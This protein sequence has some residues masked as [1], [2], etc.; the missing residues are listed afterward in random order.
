MKTFPDHR[1]GFIAG[2]LL[3]ASSATQAHLAAPVTLEFEGLSGA[4]VFGAANL[5]L[6]G[7]ACQGSGLCYFED[8]LIIGVVDD[9]TPFTGEHLHRAGSAGD[10]DLSYHSDSSGIYGRTTDGHE[11]ALKSMVFNAPIST[12]VDPLNPDQGPNDFWEILGFNVA[13]NPDLDL[14]DGTTYATRVAY[15]TVAN[16]FTGTLTLNEDFHDINAF[17]IHYRG[18]P[19]V[20]SVAKDFAVRIDDL[21]VGPAEVHAVPVPA[22]GVWMLG[23]GF[24]SLAGFARRRLPRR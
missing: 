15:Q 14:G 4:G 19:T 17:W 22:V 7:G 21:V 10:R 13:V 2:A 20:P 8:G 6:S 3:L 24:A 18:F 11:F 1:A 5:A 9:R 16:G 12:T 23:G